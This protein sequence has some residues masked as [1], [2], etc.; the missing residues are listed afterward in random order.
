MT[1][2]LLVFSLLAAVNAETCPLPD[3]SAGTPLSLTDIMG[4]A[5]MDGDALFLRFAPIVLVENYSQTYNRIGKPS[6]RHD[7]NGKEELYINPDTPVFYTQK[8]TWEGDRGTYTNLIYR[9][10]FE[11]TLSD[12]KAAS[13]STGK[14]T[15]LM[16][17]VTLNAEERPL[18]LNLVHTCGCF[19]AIVPTNY[20]PESLY[21]VKWDI[22]MQTV[23]GEQLPGKIDFPET[24][25]E[26]V[27]PVIFL[28]SGSHRVTDIS[29]ATMEA[30]QTGYELKPV[31]VE[32]MTALKHIPLGDGETSFYYESGRNKGLVKGAIKKKESV[33]FG[34]WMGDSRVGQDREFGTKEDTGRLFYTTLNPLKKQA[35]DMSDYKGFL[36]LNGWKS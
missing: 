1:W 6:A 9:F 22:A 16:V 32:P 11:E 5:A 36:E 24:G 20:L 17:I 4:F 21:P 27:H 10:H 14:N 15:G 25:G 8:E 13:I 23:Y 34:A 30:V 29:A 18:W 26:D 31:A 28:R 12:G 3:A 35:S 7:K 33:L 2:P 19:H